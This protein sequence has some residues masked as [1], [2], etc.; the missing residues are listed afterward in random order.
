MLSYRDP[1]LARTLGAFDGAAR[2]AAEGGFSAEE[3]KEAVLG[4]FGDLD[5]P[6]SPAGKGEREFASQEQGLTREMRQRLRQGVLAVERL[7]LAALAQRYL[8]EGRPRS[9]VAAVASDEALR[10]ANQELGDEPLV[11]E[12]L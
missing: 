11:M 2:W 5:R 3:V 7:G 1:H 8:I 6:L 10:K 9:S 12:R 4:V